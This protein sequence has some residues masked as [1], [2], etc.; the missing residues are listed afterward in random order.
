VIVICLGSYS[1]QSGPWSNLAT[2]VAQSSALADKASQPTAPEP[3][4]IPQED[5]EQLRRTI[6]KQRSDIERLRAKVARLEE[7]LQ[8][9]AIRDR[10]TQ[11]ETRGQ[12]LH[13][14]LFAIAEREAGLQSRLDEVN[15]QL[16]P[17]NIDAMPIFGST[18]PE[19]VR[20]SARRRLTNEAQR[21]QSQLDLLTQNKN[22]IQSSLS[23]TDL[24]I[25]NL[26]GQ[27]Q[28]AAS[29]P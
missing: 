19:E 16:R 3:S 18:R 28:N 24:V 20:E 11:E 13:A 26:Q 5:V 4:E 17:A 10:L 27:L 9:E 25:L 22:R 23:A 8:P 29:R 12:S 1:G 2:V 14:E 15:E 7:R 6:R 21:I